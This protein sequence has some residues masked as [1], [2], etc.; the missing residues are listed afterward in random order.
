LKS[1]NRHIHIHGS[2]RHHTENIVP[3]PYGITTTIT[4]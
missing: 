3:P 2:V 4:S 1:P